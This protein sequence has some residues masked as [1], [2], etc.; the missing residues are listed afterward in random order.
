MFYG[1]KKRELYYKNR[2]FIKKNK[3]IEEFLLLKSN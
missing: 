2:W 3:G 1:S